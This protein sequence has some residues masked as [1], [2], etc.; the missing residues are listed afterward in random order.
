MKK[1]VLIYGFSLEPV[2]WILL[3]FVL[4]TLL[5]RNE[6]VRDIVLA[7]GIDFAEFTGLNPLKYL[8]MQIFLVNAFI[9]QSISNYKGFLSLPL[10]ILDSARITLNILPFYD[11]KLRWLYYSNLHEI[12]FNLELLLL[13]GVI[14][15]GFARFLHYTDIFRIG[16]FDSEEYFH[17]KIGK[18]RKRVERKRTKHGEKSAYI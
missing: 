18:I 15:Y 7:M 8:F 2:K 1:S 17:K 5:V 16:Y 3:G 10:Y 6:Y 4:S 14:L 11:L 9:W 13:T 12:L